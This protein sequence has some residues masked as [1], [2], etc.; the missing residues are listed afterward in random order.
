MPTTLSTISNT[1]VKVRWQEPYASDGLNRKV[2]VAI[3]SGVY[4]GLRLS[5]SVATLSVD[6]TPDSVFGDHVA[7]QESFDGHSTTYRDDTS[8]TITLSLGGYT[9]SDVIVVVLFINYQ[10]GSVTSA[11]YRG[12]LLSEY[13]ALSASVKAGLV[14]LG[15][16]LR[17]ASGIIPASNIVHDR[18]KIA[19]LQRTDEATPWNPL[20]RNGGFELG[21]TNGTYRHA[22]PFWKSSLTNVNFMFRPVETEAHSGVKSL[23]LTTSAAGAVVATIQQDLWMPVVPGRLIMGRLYKKV[24][25]T[26]TSTP[27]GRMRFLFGDKDGLN[28]TQDDLVFAITPID[29]SFVEFD[30]VVQVPAGMRVLKAV[31]IIISGTYAA[32][33][34]CIRI[35]D[36]GAWAQ[37][38]AADWLD[39]RDARVPETAVGDMFLG[40]A[41]AFGNASAKLSFDGALINIERRDEDLAQLPPAISI[42]ARTTGSIEY[43]LLFQSIPSGTY[44]YRK[45]MSATGRMCDVVNASYNNTTNLW[46]K[47]VNGQP[48]YKQ[49]V[50]E[51]GLSSYSRVSD[52]AW[53]DASWIQHIQTV[54]PQIVTTGNPLFAPLLMTRD[55][56]GNQR[57]AI[58][59]LGLRAGRVT[60]Y[61]QNWSPPMDT[62]WF[63]LASG[64]GSNSI[65]YDDVNIPGPAQRQ[66][67]NASGDRAGSYTGF[68]TPRP[69]PATQ[70]HVVEWELSCAD[71]AGTPA[72]QWQAGFLHDEGGD[73]SSENYAKFSKTSASANWF[74]NTQG[75]GTGAGS[76]DTG[77]AAGGLQRFRLE[78][79]G[80]AF[81]GGVRVLGY[82]NG[83]LVA[84]RTANLPDASQSMSLSFAFKATGIVTNKKVILSPVTYNVARILSDDAL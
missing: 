67:V 77:V 25:Q 44:G 26:A 42:Q 47:D 58:D 46:T 33:G 30:G 6:L 45:Y 7:V 27:T 55:P 64:T 24:I 9:T 61:H 48:A 68:I 50:R 65:V 69:M 14:V 70:V 63:S 13:D 39:I 74:L 76:S 35:D 53:A 83:S 36:V 15:T 37:V 34:P 60:T 16:V 81:P 19:F 79:Y 40:A 2:A 38:D 82:I 72:L 59:H 54:N 49:E 12:Y 41:N 20:I 21:Q 11:E 57:V 23:E 10:S 75:N 5:V 3:P 62:A 29:G 8:G 28:D 66:F 17:P 32:P 22:S 51:T 52:T 73:P 1:T 4:R 43:T 84:Q 80:A 56:A 31:Q 18:R 71:L 78:Y